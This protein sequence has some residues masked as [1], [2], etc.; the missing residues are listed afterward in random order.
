M[1][2]SAYEMAAQD[3][4]AARRETTAAE[5]VEDQAGKVK[6]AKGKKSLGKKSKDEEA[7]AT[8]EEPKG[9]A[10]ISE[11]TLD[12]RDADL[13]GSYITKTYDCRIRKGITFGYLRL[14]QT[15]KNSSGFDSLMLSGI[16]IFGKLHRGKHQM[17]QNESCG[18]RFLIYRAPC[19][20]PRQEVLKREAYRHD[21]QFSEQFGENLIWIGM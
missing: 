13:T 1:W 4:Q 17:P 12:S 11:P 9:Q 16:E 2:T 10:P 14:R 5:A 7:P 21:P 6:K 3:R 18:T 8:A 20:H 19:L 15:G